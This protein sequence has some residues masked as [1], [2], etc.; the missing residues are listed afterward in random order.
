MPVDETRRH[1]LYEAARRLIDDEEAATLMDFL[2][3]TGWADVATRRDLELLEA[4]LDARIDG[5]RAEVRG[6]MAEL[7]GGVEGL[8]H[9]EL[10]EQTTRLVTWMI[11][12]WLSSVGLAL[13]VKLA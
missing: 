8:L 9:R 13:A 10:R 5:L 7:R 11:P 1:R 12:T 4:R 6:E 3:P 2:P